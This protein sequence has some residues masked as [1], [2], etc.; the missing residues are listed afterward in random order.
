MEMSQ[1]SGNVMPL[2]LSSP[3]LCEDDNEAS[4]LD[5]EGETGSTLVEAG[6]YVR[7][8]VFPYWQPRL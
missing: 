6:K 5:G 4:Q 7:N 8:Y 1:A 2:P 3:T